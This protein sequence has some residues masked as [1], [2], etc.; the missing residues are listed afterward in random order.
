MRAGNIGHEHLLGTT[1][2]FILLRHVIIALP[3]FMNIWVMFA[4]H[5]LL[6]AINVN[7][8]SE[9]TISA[10]KYVAWTCGWALKVMVLSSAGLNM[11]QLMLISRLHVIESNINIPVVSIIFVLG[12][13]L[14]T[15]YMVENKMLKDENN[16]FI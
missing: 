3:Y 14:L 12:A 1:Y 5:R 16:Q 4:A 9:E 13:L 2:V 11:L 8:Y 15:R 6:E 10:A 7:Q